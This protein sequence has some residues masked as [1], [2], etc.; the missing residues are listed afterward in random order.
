MGRLLQKKSIDRKGSTVGTV[1]WI[2]L[3]QCFSLSVRDHEKFSQSR[4]LTKI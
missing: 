3:L 1:L 2:T 4:Y